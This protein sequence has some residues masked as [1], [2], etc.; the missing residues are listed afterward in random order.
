MKIG[1]LGTGSIGKTLARKLAVAG[2]DVKVANS[3]GPDSIEAEVLEHGARAVTAEEA[4]AN[5]EVAI[6]SIPLNAMT[7]IRHLIAALPEDVVVIDTSNYYPGRDGQIAAI[8]AGQTESEWVSEQ[9]G[10]SIVKAWNAIG[11]HS[12]AINGKPEGHAERIAIPV[13]ADQQQHRDIG[14]A[15]VNETGFDGYDAGTLAESWRQQPAAPAYTTDLTYAEMGPALAAA[16]RDRLPKRRD[17]TFA[18]VMERY[19]Y[20]PPDVEWNKTIT[21]VINM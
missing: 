13:A 16:E 10:R 3:R 21:R 4:L 5:V 19:G 12:F 6:I 2:H 14:I 15:L 20:T 8:D 18:I 7:K 17:L 9:L 1:I 11:A